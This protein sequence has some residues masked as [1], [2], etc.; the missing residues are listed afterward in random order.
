[1]QSKGFVPVA[2]ENGMLIAY[3]TAEG[4]LASDVGAGAGPYAKALAEEIVKPSV[5]A[6]V[7]FRA[8]QRRVRAAIRQE[9]YLGFNGLDDV[10]LA[11]RSDQPAALSVTPPQWGWSTAER[12]WQ[13]YGKD[14]NDIRLLEAFREKHKADLVYARLAEARIE[15]LK[16]EED[17]KAEAGRLA[18]LREEDAK[19]EQQMALARSPIKGLALVPINS[20]LRTKY[21]IPNA[22]N[23]GVIVLNVEGYAAQMG[24]KVGDVIVEVSNAEVSSIE[25]VAREIEKTKKVGRNAVLVRVED[26][27]IQRFIALP[28]N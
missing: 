19:A 17:R 9:P 8:V 14:T 5:E 28:L 18:K 20:Q 24:I 26:N 22:I 21:R 23:H 11:G 25:D 10:Y 12:E 6:V 15:E 2:Q 13:Q 16:R 1:V 7:M 4:E 27:G 3:A